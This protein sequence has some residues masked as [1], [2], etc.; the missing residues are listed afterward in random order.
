[1]LTEMHYLFFLIVGKP[2]VDMCEFCTAELSLTLISLNYAN[3]SQFDDRL[4]TGYGKTMTGLKKNEFHNPIKNA[5][6]FYRFRDT[7]GQTAKISDLGI[8][9]DCPK[10]G[11]DLFITDMHHYAKFHVNHRRQNICNQTETERT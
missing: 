3:L 1:M 7:H 4:I 10:R 11:E 9:T 8:P 2:D 6:Y 5:T